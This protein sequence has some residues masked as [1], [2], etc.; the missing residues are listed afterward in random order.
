M[1]LEERGPSYKAKGAQE[2]EKTKSL[3]RD[4]GEEEKRRWGWWD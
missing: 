2:E 1:I 3:V 4:S